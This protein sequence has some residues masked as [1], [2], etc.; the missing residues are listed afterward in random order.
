MADMDSLD[1]Q[2][3]MIRDYVKDIIEIVGKNDLDNTASEV[4]K[5]ISTLSGRLKIHLQTEDKFL[6]PKLLTD[7]N[8]EIRKT[9]ELYIKEMGNISTEFENYKNQFNTRSKICADIENFKK[10]TKLIFQVLGKRLDQ[11]DGHLYPM[12]RKQV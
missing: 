10:Q 8:A 6:Y 5:I 1:K 9:T 11:E 7:N 2:H 4:A 3:V 12:I